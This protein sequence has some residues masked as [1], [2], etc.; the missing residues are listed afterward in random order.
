MNISQTAAE[1]GT[2]S[3]L[4]HPRTRSVGRTTQTIPAIL[5]LNGTMGVS[6]I[7]T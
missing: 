7:G 1:D 2:E 6:C 4:I 5:W 3:S